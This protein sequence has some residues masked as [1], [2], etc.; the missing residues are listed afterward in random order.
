MK[1]PTSACQ[2]PSLKTF[3]HCVSLRTKSDSS[4]A[5]YFLRDAALGVIKPVFVENEEKPR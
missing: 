2:S 4:K 1:F 5:A 3:W